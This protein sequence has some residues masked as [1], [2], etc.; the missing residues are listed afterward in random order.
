[1]MFMCWDIIVNSYRLIEQ[2][3]EDECLVFSARGMIYQLY[4]RIAE[5][6]KFFQENL[7]NAQQLKHD[8]VLAGVF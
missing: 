5:F 6:E 2:F 4:Q 3:P 7:Q 8:P 1:M